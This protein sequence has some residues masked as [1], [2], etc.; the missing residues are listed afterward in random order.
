MVVRC[1]LEKSLLFKPREL[2]PVY[3]TGYLP[4]KI[5]GGTS[6]KITLH[7]PIKECSPT[8]QN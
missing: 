2:M 8:L 6:C 1:L 3:L 5:N 7:A 4:A